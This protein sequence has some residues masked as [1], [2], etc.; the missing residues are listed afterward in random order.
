MHLIAQRAQERKIRFLHAA[1]GRARA[2]RGGEQF[3][4]GHKALK[5]LRPLW[6]RAFWPE[7]QRL[8]AVQNADGQ[9]PPAYGAYVAQFARLAGFQANAAVAVP[10]QMVLA[11][12][13]IKFQRA[14]KPLARL[15]GVRHGGIGKRAIQQIGFPAQLGGRV[16]IGIGDEREPIQSRH[17][18]VHRRIGRE[19]GFHRV[20]FARQ[21][22]KALFQAIEAGKRAQQGKVRRPDVGGDEHG[23]RAGVQRD[24]QQIAAIEAQN[25]PA[26]RMDVANGLQPLRKRLRACE[27][28]QKDHAMHF[29]GFAIL[30][31]NGADFPADHKARRLALHL[32]GQTQI[33]LQRIQPFFRRFQRVF[34]LFAPGRVGKIARGHQRNA[35]APRP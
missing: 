22:A 12:F 31:I 33:W 9:P 26:I 7:S 8:H 25:R 20:N 15:D 10:V 13:W 5:R 16:R 2:Q 28:R 30:L 18:P 6:P 1:A 21:I 29:A 19:P 17:A 3:R 27:I 14:A 11:L 34:Q 23:A 4:Q 35:L 32:A 24:L